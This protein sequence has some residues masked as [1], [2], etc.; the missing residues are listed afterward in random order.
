PALRALHHVLRAAGLP[1]CVAQT[2]V[3]TTQFDVARPAPLRVVHAADQLADAALE[4]VLAAEGA[5]AADALEEMLLAAELLAR[6]ARRPVRRARNR[7]A[8]T[9]LRV[10]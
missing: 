6:F 7:A 4:R 1:R 5:A 2:L 3:L 9:G 8:A 10:L